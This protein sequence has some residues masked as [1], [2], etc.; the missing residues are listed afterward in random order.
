MPDKSKFRQESDESQVDVSDTSIQPVPPNPPVQY[1]KPQKQA[2]PSPTVNPKPTIEPP[3]KK[4]DSSSG[5]EVEIDVQARRICVIG[6]LVTYTLLHKESS[7]EYVDGGAT[8]IVL[9]GAWLSR[10]FTECALIQLSNRSIC[11]DAL[12]EECLIE[13]GIESSVNATESALMLWEAQKQTGL[14]L[15]TL[16]LNTIEI[17]GVSIAK[18]KLGENCHEVRLI[19]N[20]DISGTIGAVCNLVVSMGG[21][22]KVH[23]S[24]EGTATMRRVFGKFYTSPTT[25]I[26]LGEYSLAEFADQIA[27]KVT[28]SCDRL[29]SARL[30]LENVRVV[31]PNG[32]LLEV[33]QIEFASCC[34]SLSKVLSN[35]K[36]S[37]KVRTPNSIRADVFGYPRKAKL[38][39]NI[40]EAYPNFTLELKSYPG[41]TV[42]T[43]ERDKSAGLM[44]GVL[45]IKDEPALFLPTRMERDGRNFEQLGRLNDEFILEK[46]DSNV[47]DQLI[48]NY[49][50]EAAKLHRIKST[51][52]SQLESMQSV[53][54]DQLIELQ[55]KINQALE[56]LASKVKRVYQESSIIMIEDLGLG[57]RNNPRSSNLLFSALNEMA[58]GKNPGPCL[59]VS[60][61]R[62]MPTMDSVF[63]RELVNEC[64]NKSVI[65]LSVDCMRAA[66]AKISRGISWERIAFETLQ[67]IRDNPAMGILRQL[68]HVVVRF[69]IDGALYFSRVKDSF[70]EA[71]ASLFYRPS[72]IEGDF[73]VRSG[74]ICCESSIIASAISATIAV[75]DDLRSNHGKLKWKDIAIG[76]GI[77]TGLSACSEFFKRG[78]GKQLDGTAA[79]GSI[80]L[81]NRKRIEYRILRPDLDQAQAESRLSRT[82][83][84]LVDPSWSVLL[85]RGKNSLYELSISIVQKG[86]SK[87]LCTGNQ[88]GFDAPFANFGKAWFVDRREIESFRS[89]Q[90]LMCEYLSRLTV[91][92]PLSVAV[93][94]PP[95]AGK[96]FGIKQIADRFKS[97]GYDLSI[98]EYNLAQFERY[99]DLEEA[100]IRVQGSI[101]KNH[102]PMVFFDEFDCSLDNRALGWLKYFLSP[103]QDGQFRH[104]GATLGIGKSIFVFG[105]GTSRTFQD[106]TRVSSE[107]SDEERISFKQAKGP[108][109]VSRLK[110]HVDIT[111]PDSRDRADDGFIVRRAVLV[112]SILEQ[113]QATGLLAKNANDA[114]DPKLLHAIL[115]VKRFEHGARSIES[116]IEMCSIENGRLSP[117]SLPTEDQLEM[118][119]NSHE[120]LNLISG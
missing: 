41:W 87:A 64:S 60:C 11:G 34:V 32:S 71:E 105:G 56:S 115:T 85:N 108:D 45:R 55:R 50:K 111:G 102:I 38:G 6:D 13:I 73:S 82:A 23:I 89:M 35:F 52:F 75:S 53:E 92:R 106:F 48:E 120:F 72:T 14:S 77:L 68:R 61:D 27:T 103:M 42:G 49:V 28:V 16:K 109:F 36:T 29:N 118:H 62:V 59:V 46:F 93:F 39:V 81:E 15:S 79:F 100:L 80:E 51:R 1:P 112:R 43:K 44:A 99:F 22:G 107:I 2:P 3:I 33:S 97:D 90:R 67:Q 116:I 114:I 65:V 20:C 70:T 104:A 4:P 117:T 101:A 5:E 24:Q 10:R 40:T 25:Q 88:D 26:D 98:H 113:M 54:S 9:G 57:F 84:S 17:Q 31:M 7:A 18:I 76:R 37:A 95:G 69:G 30:I 58:V 86:V 96:S 110:G 94:G 63:W 66:G 47:V 119:V 74:S 91:V 21:E 8:R 83:V 78:F 19:G 12:D